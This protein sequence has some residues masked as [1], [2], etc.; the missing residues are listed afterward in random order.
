MHATEHSTL[1][2]IQYPFYYYQFLYAN[3]FKI[4]KM[5]FHYTRIAMAKEL[6]WLNN[7]NIKFPILSPMQKYQI[8]HNLVDCRKKEINN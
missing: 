5:V 8:G 7:L 6:G 1:Q 2:C 3:I 4:I